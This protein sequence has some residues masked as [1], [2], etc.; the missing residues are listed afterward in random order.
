MTLTS[1]LSF[2]NSLAVSEGYLGIKTPFIRT[3]KFNI[4]R[5]GDPIKN[6]AYLKKSV[7]PL[8]LIEGLLSMYFVSGIILGVYYQEFGFLPWH[9]MLA[10]GFG[11]VFYRSI[12]PFTR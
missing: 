1:G 5:K 4:S 9:I 7:S 2:H 10:I 8:V 11:F 6:D 3:P 12:I